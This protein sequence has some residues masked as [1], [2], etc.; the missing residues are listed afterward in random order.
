MKTRSKL[1]IMLMSAVSMTFSCD[2]VQEPDEPQVE[3][4]DDETGEGDDEQTE[5]SIWD[6]S[7]VSFTIGAEEPVVWAVGDVVKVV[8]LSVDEKRHRISL[9]M[10]QAKK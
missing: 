4:P 1:L 5:P 9:S 10:K 2:K 3:I 6:G 7:S 8:V